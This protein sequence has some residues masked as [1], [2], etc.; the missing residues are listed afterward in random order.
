MTGNNFGCCFL[1]QVYGNK[2]FGRSREKAPLR[3]QLSYLGW[4]PSTTDNQRNASPSVK[5]LLRPTWSRI[6]D[7][8]TLDGGN[9]TCTSC[10]NFPRN[11]NHTEK[12]IV[13]QKW[14]KSAK[15]SFLS[16]RRDTP[17]FQKLKQRL[18]A[19]FSLGF[20]AIVSIFAGDSIFT[21]ALTL[22]CVLGQLEYYRMARAKGHLPAHRAGIFVGVLQNI[23]AYAFPTFADTVFPIGGTLICCYLLF[24]KRQA[25]I[26]DI[27]TSFM[28]LFYAGYLPSYWIRLHA[29]RNMSGLGCH[30][31]ILR[32]LQSFS[33]L[34]WRPLFSLGACLTFWTWLSIVGADVGAYFTGKLFG[35]TKF[36]E[37]SPKKTVEGALGGFLGSTFISV[38]AAYLLCF[39]FWYISGAVYGIMIGVVGLLGDL[40]ASLFKRDAGFKDSGNIIPGHGGILDRTDSYVFTAPLVYYFVTILIPFIVQIFI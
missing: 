21:L 8:S 10:E 35:R 9:I 23:V 2:L 36:I 16:F 27:S 13:E 4:I 28:G 25:T 14:F 6:S 7:G 1:E 37:I 40:T 5:H 24:R 3:K 33:F 19:G 11:K 32:F 29:L 20:L 17:V 15:A 31:V 34:G 26:A 39:P 12:S 18:V 38:L 22:I 30:T